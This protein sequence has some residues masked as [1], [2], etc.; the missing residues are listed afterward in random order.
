MRVI[1]ATLSLG[2][3][4]LVA[5]T[6]PLAFE[7]ATVKPSPMSASGVTGGCHG[8]DSVYTPNQISSAPP[9]GRCVIHDARLAHMIC[10]AFRIPAMNLIKSGPDWIQRGEE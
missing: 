6:L 9:L 5:Q 4:T 10:I 8:I 1:L 3:A 2:V 7:V